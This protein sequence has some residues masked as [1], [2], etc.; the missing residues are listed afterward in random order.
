M[1][2]AMPAGDALVERTTRY[3]W[4]VLIT[5]I[6]W[7]LFSVIVFRFDYTTVTAIAVL[8]GIVSIAI[9]VSELFAAMLVHGWWRVLAIVAGVFFVAVGIVAFTKPGNTFVGLAAVVSFYFVI[10]GSWNLITGIWTRKA[11]SAWWVQT[12]TGVIELALGF[13]AA[14]YWSRSVTLLVAWVGAMA[15]IRGIN[16]IVLAFRLHEAHEAATSMT[17]RTA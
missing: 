17:P 4:L 16:E 14:G 1:P 2:F 13:W 15:L 12:I 6:A 7:I 9:G 3:W 5:G 10:A 8:F 11:N